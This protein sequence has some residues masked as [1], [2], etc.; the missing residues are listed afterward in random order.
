MKDGLKLFMNARNAAA[1]S[2][3][4][5]DPKI[6]ASRSLD[7]F[8]YHLPNALNYG[9]KIIVSFRLFKEIRF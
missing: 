6:T 7:A 9:I 4:Q 5:L 2:V 1:G 8:M 3:R